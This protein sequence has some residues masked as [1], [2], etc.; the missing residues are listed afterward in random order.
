MS[1]RR[2]AAQP[3]DDFP[4]AKRLVCRLIEYGADLAEGDLFGSPRPV[5]PEMFRALADADAA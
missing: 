1:T 4:S 3:A 5:T 2:T